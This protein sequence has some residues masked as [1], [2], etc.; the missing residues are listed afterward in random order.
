MKSICLINLLLTILLS[1]K[2]NASTKTLGDWANFQQEADNLCRKNQHEDAIKIYDQVIKGRLPLQGNRHRDIGVAWNNL[3]VAY[4]SQGENE[5][6]YEAYQKA[7]KILLP[8]VGAEHPDILIVKT[9][10]A[11][12][13]ESKNNFETAE[14]SFRELLQRKLPIVGA[15]HPELAD[16]QE[17]LALS[18][19]GQEKL[20]EALLLLK[21]ALLT[22][23][24][25]LGKEHTD[26]GAT[27]AA[28]AIIF[29]NQADFDNANKHDEEARKI[30]SITSGTYPP[31]LNTVS[32]LRP[33]PA[34][35]LHA[36]NKDLRIP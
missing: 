24:K 26:V 33:G 11:F 30:L 25:K 22:R 19:V 21:K 18:L 34:E 27:H 36:K 8:A 14:K 4:Y 13:E 32:R 12:V 20:E 9:N 31:N 17:G 35:L 1:L 23:I 28:I 10:I 16:C 15:E 29:L 2:L 6:A 3:G 7:I 5:R